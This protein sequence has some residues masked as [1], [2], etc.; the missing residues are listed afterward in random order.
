M[1]KIYTKSGDGGNTVLLGGE[2][3][4]KDCISLQVV[5][6][7]DELNSTLGEVVAHLENA[8]PSDF[9]IQI[10]KDLFR[11]GAEI[12]AGQNAT[13][14]KGEKISEKEIGVLENKM[15]E[16]ATVLPE[17]KN[18]IL[19]GGSLSGAHLHH[20]RTICRRAERA[21]VALG[22]TQTVRAEMYKYFNRLSDYLFMAARWVNFQA[23]IGEEKI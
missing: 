20:A 14:F 7:M 18:F 10:Q 21:L 1:S 2:K 9:L 17:L 3:V 22:K 13:A 16:Y 8:A 6:E 11:A 23:K 12:A 19:P 4:T 5:G 15:D